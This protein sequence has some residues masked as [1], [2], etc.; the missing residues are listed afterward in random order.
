MEPTSTTFII[1]I[2]FGVAALAFFVTPKTS[3]KDHV[4]MNFLFIIIIALLLTLFSFYT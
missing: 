1:G 2:F 4:A 3:R